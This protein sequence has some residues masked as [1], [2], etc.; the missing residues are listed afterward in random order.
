M[1]T[2]VKNTRS[3]AT[4]TPARARAE[5]AK[6]KLAARDLTRFSEFVDPQFRRA[7]HQIYVA[8]KL[9]DVKRFIQTGE[10]IRR[11][12]ILEPP[13][14]GKSR[15]ASIDFPAW[16]LGELH[17]LR[18]ILTSYGADLAS[19]NSRAMR[20]LVND[21]KYQAVFGVQ[22]SLDEPVMLSSDSRSS[23][24]WDLARPNRGG[25]LAAGVGGAVTGFG[26]DLFVIDDPFKNREEA[27]SESRRELV[28]DWWKSSVQ[29]RLSPNGAVILFHTRWHPDDQAG[30]LIK[31][32]ITDPKADQ[33]EIVCLP[34]LALED[35][36][37]AEKQKEMMREGV[38]MPI[39]DSLGREPGEAL[40]PEK[41]S[42]EWLL[43]KQ[44]NIGGYDFEALYQQM[45]Y[46]REGQFFKREWFKIVNDLPEGVKLVRIV[47]YW[48]KA[49]SVKGDYTVGVLMGKGSDGLIYI[50]NVVRGKWAPYERDQQMLKAVREATQKWAPIS[51]KVWHQR[52]PAS[53]GLDSAMA[54]NRLLIG[55]PVRFEPATGSK[56]DR[57]DPFAAA[58]QGDLVRLLKGVWNQAYIDE[59]ASFP[60]GRYD[61]QVDGSSGSFNRLT[62]GAAQKEV[63]S[64]QG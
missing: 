36:P 9:M 59:L 10:G 13:Q 51:V 19:R 17:D 53:A 11:L 62:S 31:R 28:D 60:R 64:Y 43:D 18:V 12:M 34:A 35:Y 26:A 63:T 46:P 1:L 37:D 30:R 55:F 14:H 50:L 33:W 16:M 57:A 15:Q 54:T 61:D 25:V 44:I 39:G 38:Y 58:C 45:P 41:Y 29:T 8:Q 24:S 27:E 4:I 6:R 21:A 56:E 3:R 48:D 20:D 40:W 23:T 42:K 47:F 32:M 2:A 49:G 22:S 5:L 7:A 52:D